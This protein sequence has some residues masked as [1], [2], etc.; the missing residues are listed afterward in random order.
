MI[1]KQSHIPIYIQIE[2]ILLAQIDGGSLTPGDPIPSET[3][4]A[5]QYGVSRMTARKAVDYLVR[6][7]IVERQRGRGTFICEQAQD[8]KMSLPL[9]SHLTSSEVATSLN[10]PIVN[11]LLHLEKVTAPNKVCEELGIAPNSQVWFMKRLRL[12][13]S[14][15]FVFESTH[16]L[17]D[18]YFDDLSEAELNSSKYLYLESKGLKVK[19]SQKQIRAELPGEE[20]RHYLNL[21]R[22]EPVLFARS[23]AR[24]EDDTPFEVSDIYYNQEHYIFT[25][26][27]GR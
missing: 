19:G 18:P 11:Q 27:A 25:L 16:M 17:I 13:G 22:D 4:M 6:Q 12:V 5:E 26:Q 3:V 9:D 24:L 15:P 21:K 7:G 20:V 10:S 23:I 1:D 14:V 8:L 2:Q